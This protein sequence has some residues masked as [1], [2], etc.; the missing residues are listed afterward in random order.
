MQLS[1]Y[2]N[3]KVCVLREGKK[4]SLVQGNDY[5]PQVSLSCNLVEPVAQM[6]QKL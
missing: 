6:I 1:M 2:L 5:L 4:D 3:S